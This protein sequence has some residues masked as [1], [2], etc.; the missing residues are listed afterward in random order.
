MMDKLSFKKDKLNDIQLTLAGA[1][2]NNDNHLEFSEWRNDLKKWENLS[3]CLLF[4]DS[5]KSITP[6]S[7]Q[8]R[9]FAIH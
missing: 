2:A 8:H 1:D 7:E 3:A 9:K 6:F 4:C 5:E